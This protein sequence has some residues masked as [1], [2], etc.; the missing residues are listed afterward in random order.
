MKKQSVLKIVLAMIFFGMIVMSKNT[1]EA[2][3]YDGP[4]GVETI[5]SQDPKSVIS[6][7]KEQQ[8]SVNL[9]DVQNSNLMYCIEHDQRL[10]QQK[11]TYDI[12]AYV[13]IEDGVATG[14]NWT[15]NGVSGPHVS[16]YSGRNQ[17]F[18][19]ILSGAYGLGYGSYGNYTPAQQAVYGYISEWIGTNENPRNSI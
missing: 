17:V 9:P 7:G 8:V 10:R 3:Y 15:E 16:S 18:A 4:S 14:Y 2:A 13:K 19:Q 12:L 5:F 1:V 11:Q 6:K